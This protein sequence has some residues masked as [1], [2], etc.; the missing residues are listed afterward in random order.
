MA[1]TETRPVGAVHVVQVVAILRQEL[2]V[3][4]VE[5]Q[6]VAARLELGD[7]TVALE[8]LVTRMRVRVEPVVVWA[9]EAVLSQR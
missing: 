8:V 6:T 7:A 2:G 9:L 5:G 3:S 4:G 1:L